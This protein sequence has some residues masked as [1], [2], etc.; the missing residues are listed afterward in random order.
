MSL[1]NGSCS[2][3]SQTIF[4]V[5]GS[6]RAQGEAHSIPQTIKGKSRLPLLN[7]GCGGMR[8]V[9]LTFL[10]RYFYKVRSRRISSCILPW[11]FLQK[12]GPFFCMFFQ[13]KDVIEILN[14]D[15]REEELSW[16][17][18]E[19][20]ALI[21]DYR[22]ALSYFHWRDQLT[23]TPEPFPPTLQDPFS[24]FRSLLDPAP[25]RRKRYDFVMKLD[26]EFGIQNKE[27]WFE[28]G[29]RKVAGVLPGM[30]ML[31]QLA[32]TYLH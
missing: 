31:N 9:D 8:V 27:K 28:T 11:W 7:W 18:N 17:G 12:Y 25:Q 10:H 32:R 4:R 5:K 16:A 22:F 30:K 3:S 20:I 23:N 14:L 13:E 26:E 1:L 29:Q 15:V 2:F 21:N 6:A 24:V 19:P